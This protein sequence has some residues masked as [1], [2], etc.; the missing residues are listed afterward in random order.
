MAFELPL[1]AAQPP[2][3]SSSSATSCDR[4]P[5]EFV[6]GFCASCLRERLAGL[7]PAASATASS[8]SRRG[9]PSSAASAAIKSL[10]KASVAPDARGKPPVAAAGAS[11]SSAAFSAQLRRCKSFSGGRGGPSAAAAFEP[12][13]RSC[14]V[15]GRNTLWNLFNLDDDRHQNG[16][17]SRVVEIQPPPLGEIEIECRDV[18]ADD[19]LVVEEDDEIRV[20]EPV[21]A[22]ATVDQEEIVEEEVKTIKDHIDVDAQA[23][24]P[25]PAKDL[26]EIAGSF[27][28]AASVF[29]KKLQKWRRKQKLKKKSSPSSA[30]TAGGAGKPMPMEK[31]RS[32]RWGFRDTQSEVA[33][34]IYGRRSC[35]TD[36]RFSLD[37]GR[38]SF[39]DPRQS[40]DE[41]RASWDGYL[42]AGRPPPFP[43]F[44][45]PMLSVVEDAPIPC[46]RSDALIPVE[47]PMEATTPGGTAQTRDYYSDSSQRRRKSLDRS[48]S[49][50]API[51]AEETKSGSN[52]KVTDCYLHRNSVLDRDPRDFNSNSLRDDCSES[53]E[54]A[55]RDAA[56]IS[57]AGGSKKSRRWSKAWSIWG[58]IHRRGGKDDDDGGFNRSGKIMERSLSES[59]PELRREVTCRKVARSNSS[60]SSR[61]SVNGGSAF[62]GIRGNNV[63]MNGHSKFK[64]RR[65]EF[66]LERNRSARYSP[67][68]VDN[69]LLR[70]YLTPMRSSSRRGGGGGGS[71]K[72][73]QKSSNSFARTVLR[74]Y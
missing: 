33:E 35:D 17:Q 65:E 25:P 3:L 49:R 7:D 66:V 31:P 53:F 14:D 59:W 2:R 24:P 39:D 36:P 71:V 47:E 45:P 64:K 34:D 22:P 43:R 28:L 52:A 44:F 54:S 6:T 72:S 60:V 27:W 57:K 21:V 58:F 55:F 38:M 11:S 29:S 16:H 40:W 32:R 4:H 19:A 23:K 15:R 70:F 42:I 9:K 12:Q 69:G 10:F 63:E 30:A 56:S 50:K 8:S 20:S 67:G 62:G 37:A 61:S 51:E 48:S 13:R 18:A 1:Q 46:Q 41:P 26:K 74:L 5:D 68:H 73:Q